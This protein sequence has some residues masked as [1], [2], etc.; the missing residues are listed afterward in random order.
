L[1]TRRRRLGRRC[2]VCTVG[3]VVAHRASPSRRRIWPQKVR[4]RLST[5]TCQSSVTSP[6]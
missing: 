6:S 1:T 3:D 2:A 4:Y 5:V